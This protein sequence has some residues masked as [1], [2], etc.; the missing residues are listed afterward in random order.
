MTGFGV[1][2]IGCICV[3]VYG[4]F[5]VHDS[6]SCTVSGSGDEAID[7]YYVGVGGIYVRK[8]YSMNYI[9]DF[10]ELF[11]AYHE[12]TRD[13]FVIIQDRHEWGIFA[14]PNH[15]LIYGNIPMEPMKYLYHPP[16]DGWKLNPPILNH[17]LAIV[18]LV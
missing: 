4:W 11:N 2:L 6:V 14:M 3:L 7:G 9:P 8:G 5:S 18:S 15:Q 1:V 17:L 16:S 13:S 10:F 12:F